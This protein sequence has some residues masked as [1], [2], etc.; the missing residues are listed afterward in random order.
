MRRLLAATLLIAVIAPAGVFAQQGSQPQTTTL[1]VTRNFFNNSLQHGVAG[2]TRLGVWGPATRNQQVADSLSESLPRIQ[3]QLQALGQPPMTQAEI[4]QILQNPNL[5]NETNAGIARINELAQRG[6]LNVQIDDQ[7]PRLEVPGEQPRVRPDQIGDR[8]EQLERESPL[9]TP[10]TELAALCP[11]LQ[12]DRV[13]ADIP[14]FEAMRA[15]DYPIKGAPGID[16][17]QL[18]NGS[19]TPL[20]PRFPA[21][22]TRHDQ[23]IEL[24]NVPDPGPDGRT[25][26]RPNVFEP[27]RQFIEWERP[28]FARE[29]NP[30]VPVEKVVFLN[31]QGDDDSRCAPGQGPTTF[32]QDVQRPGPGVRP[33]STL[34]RLPPGFGPGLGGGGLGQVFMQ[35]ALL[36][37]LKRLL[38]L[39][40]QPPAPAPPPPPAATTCPTTIR[41]VCGN[42]GRTY[43]NRCVAEQEFGV[44]VQQEGRCAPRTSPAASPAAS[45]SPSPTATPVAADT[46]AFDFLFARAAD[47][48]FPASLG[49]RVL[50]LLVS[51]V[52]ALVVR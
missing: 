4:N 6:V 38:G 11:T 18:A 23:L 47:S 32:R 27:Q 1:Y 5:L 45:P 52:L 39:G 26:K 25:P 2:G 49:D 7:N 19:V 13:R 44:R 21:A 3:N 17:P 40:Q 20:D 29:A 36:E 9:P 43:P 34:P 48:A 10:P 31:V 50:R 42:D 14:K 30:P 12:Q 24:L 22:A 8:L 35:L 37:A 41:P 33:P 16:E 46:S 15:S 28:I 51:A